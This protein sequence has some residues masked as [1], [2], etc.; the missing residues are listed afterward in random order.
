M[1]HRIAFQIG[2]VA[3]VVHRTIQRIG[4]H[5]Q[6]PHAKRL[7]HKAESFRIL[8][9]ILGSDPQRRRTK[10]R[11]RKITR[12]RRPNRRLGSEVGIP[13][14]HVFDDKN[15]PQ[16]LQVAGERLRTHYF[17]VSVG[18]HI[19]QKTGQRRLRALISGIRTHQQFRIFCVAFHSVHSGN[20]D[21]DNGIVIIHRSFQCNSLSL[22]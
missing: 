5:S 11:I 19:F 14:G 1:Q 6:I 3:I 16:G 20:I 10:R 12:V 2:F 21:V 4:I 7:K 8:L 18:C 22:S 13:R 9:E 15:L 17:T